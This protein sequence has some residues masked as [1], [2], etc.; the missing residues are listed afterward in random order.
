MY[1]QNEEEKYIVEFFKDKKFGH[2]LSIGENDGQTFSN[3]ARLIE[4]GWGGDLVEPSPVCVKKLNTLYDHHPDV[5]VH[6]VALGTENKKMIFHESGSLIN[7]GDLSLVSTLIESEKTRWNKLNMKWEEI[8]V[9][10][11]TWESFKTLAECFQAYD[12]ISIDCE[13]MD[14][15]ILKQIDLTDVKL[16]CIE[17]NSIPEARADILNYCEKFGMKKIIYDNAENL[18]IC[19]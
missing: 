5:T 17:H 18:L 19:R 2:L 9:E 11:Y 13:G 10:V 14:F 12:F 15:D 16:L 6:Q 8:E 3:V 7:K 4:L 1:S